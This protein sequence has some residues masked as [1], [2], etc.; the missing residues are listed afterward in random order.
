MERR[1]GHQHPRQRHQQESVARLQLT[2]EAPRG[3]RDREAGDG[4]DAGG[5]HE[6]HD[7]PVLHAQRPGDG[8]QVEQAEEGHHEPEQVRDG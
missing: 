2:A 6:V 5:D 8:Q 3:Q 1:G 4:I 7:R